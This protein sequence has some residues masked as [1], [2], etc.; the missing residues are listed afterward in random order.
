MRRNE[1]AIRDRQGLYDALGR[2]RLTW[3]SHG[4]VP[5]IHG[6]TVGPRGRVHTI[7]VGSGEMAEAP[8]VIGGGVPH[9]SAADQLAIVG[10]G[11][12]GGGG[13]LQ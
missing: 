4:V 3:K 7:H 12:I 5:V 10:V 1:P 8:V 11:K 13:K 2:E 9:S 6:A